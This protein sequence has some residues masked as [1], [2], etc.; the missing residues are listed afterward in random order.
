MSKTTGKLLFAYQTIANLEVER[1]TLRTANRRLEGEVARMREALEHARLFIRNG[2][3]LGC[4]RM[5]DADTPDPAH[6]TLP[7]INA[8]L[9]TTNDEV[10]E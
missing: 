8:A 5:P 3:D 9:S 7:L 6:H 1:D 10:T 2:I 4:I